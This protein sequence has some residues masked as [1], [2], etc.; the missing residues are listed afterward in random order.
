M[1]I[2]H[3]KQE[4]QRALVERVVEGDGAW[5]A[6]LRRSAFA[7]E[8]LSGPIATLAHKTALQPTRVAEADI[9]AAKASGFGEDELFELIICAAAGQA[10][11]QYEAAPAALDKAIAGGEAHHAS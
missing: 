1:A 7:N 8:G 3:R 9:G 10:A 4:L 5:A 2:R 6:E 11:R